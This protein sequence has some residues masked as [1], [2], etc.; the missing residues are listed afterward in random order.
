[1]DNKAL[2]R[3]I[4]ELDEFLETHPHLKGLQGEIDQMLEQCGPDPIL[5]LKFLFKVM[6][7]CLEEELLPNVEKLNN[8][9]KDAKKETKDKAS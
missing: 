7:E 2:E 6:G 1:M 5:R 4:K 9:L 8:I 3:A